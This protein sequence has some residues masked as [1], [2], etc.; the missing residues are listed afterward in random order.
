MAERIKNLMRRG[1]R[2]FA[3]AALPLLPTTVP[4]ATDT[5]TVAWA[6]SD[7]DPR[8]RWARRDR[9]GRLGGDRMR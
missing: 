7:G 5:T 8:A 4:A 6:S 9:R 1:R 2:A 3:L